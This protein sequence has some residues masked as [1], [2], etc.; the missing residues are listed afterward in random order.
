MKYLKKFNEATYEELNENLSEEIQWIDD[1]VI[2][3]SDMGYNISITPFEVKSISKPGLTIRIGSTNDGKL[4]PISIGEYLLTI[5]SYLK[6]RGFVGFRPYDYDNPYSPSR[7]DVKVNALLKGVK[8]MYEN[9]L[10]QFVD[11]LKRFTV[12]A[13]FDSISVSYYKPDQTNERL[14]SFKTFETVES[15]LTSEISED[16][17]DI[18]LEL[19][20][21]GFFISKDVT[22]IKKVGNK[23]CEDVIE[24]VIDKDSKESFSFTDIE[25]YIRRLIDYMSEYK[26]NYS[27]FYFGVYSFIEF[28]CGGQH[29]LISDKKL[30]TEAENILHKSLLDKTLKD[31]SAFKIV[32]YQNIDHI[33]KESSEVLT[34]QTVKD[35][36]LSIYEEEFDSYRFR[37]FDRPKSEGY[38]IDFVPEDRIVYFNIEQDDVNKSGSVKIS[39]LTKTIF[40]GNDNILSGWNDEKIEE[41]ESI[42]S[43][44]GYH[45]LSPPKNRP[46]SACYVLHPSAEGTRLV[47]N[48]MR[49]SRYSVIPN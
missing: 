48:T 43:D 47:M 30:P 37:F 6:E 16:I 7:H 42:L 12:N 11:M 14:K 25:D 26:F 39:T 15:K 33:I 32:F 9:E 21:E 40:L 38:E 27:L 10:S 19:H 41:F 36:L 18:L 23:L 1:A 28:E 35:I 8:N 49:E 4:L 20:D 2:E 34:P 44:Y 24:I 5:D 46:T 13:P 45:L 17:K 29:P 22:D 31:I 3:L